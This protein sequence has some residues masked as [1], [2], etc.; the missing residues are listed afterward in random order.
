LAAIN[1]FVNQDSALAL[2]QLQEAVQLQDSWPYKEPPPWHV[3]MRECLGGV[4]LSLNRNSDADAT[5]RQ[6]LLD[7][8]NN[9]YALWGL[10]QAMIAQGKYTPQQIEEV[11]RQLNQAWK[12]ADVFIYSSCVFFDPL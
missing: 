9:P 5:F 8:P 2:S 3:P 7:F 6:D 1:L 4:Q 10:E 11:Q 12:N